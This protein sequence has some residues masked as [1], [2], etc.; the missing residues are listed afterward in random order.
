MSAAIFTQWI[1][2]DRLVPLRRSPSHVRAIL[3][4]VVDAGSAANRD[5]RSRGHA[6]DVRRA[7]R[8][9]LIES[10]PWRA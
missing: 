4:A 3:D 6:P 7:W 5:A 1:L 8:E 2:E 9:E 10:L